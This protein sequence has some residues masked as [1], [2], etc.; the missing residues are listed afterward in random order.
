MK[1]IDK[2][3]IESSRPNIDVLYGINYCLDA[4]CNETTKSMDDFAVK[5]LKFEEIIG[6]LLLARDE[7]NKNND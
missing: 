2:T 6:V 1:D 3:V 4:L 7:I 5:N